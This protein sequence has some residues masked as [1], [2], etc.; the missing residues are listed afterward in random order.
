M[1]LLKGWKNKVKE[2]SKKR[3]NAIDFFRGLIAIHIIMIHT[4][5]H[6]GNLYV[7]YKIQSWVL[8]FDVPIFLILSGM[9]FAFHES[10]GKKL[11]EIAKVMFKWLI[12]I[13]FCYVYLYFV[14]RQSLHIKDF[15]SWLVFNPHTNSAYTLGVSYSLWFMLP[16]IESSIICSI[17]IYFTVQGCKNDNEKIVRILLLLLLLFGVF[18]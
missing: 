14:D 11:Q 3:N 2:K 12:F 18:L 1:Q 13:C 7:P 8:L 9:T 4:V 15:T 17:L 16:F 10:P 5:F 6:S